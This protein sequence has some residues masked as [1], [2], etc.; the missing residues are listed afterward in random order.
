MNTANQKRYLSLT[1]QKKLP[2][3]DPNTRCHAPNRNSNKY[4][5]GDCKKRKIQDEIPTDIY[6]DNWEKDKRAGKY[7]KELDRLGINKE[8][9]LEWLRRGLLNWDRERII[10]Q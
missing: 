1:L 4:S 8:G 5:P 7:K 10:I 9:S 6:C 3:T 2:K